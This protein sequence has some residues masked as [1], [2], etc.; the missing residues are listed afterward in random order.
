MH[1]KRGQAAMEFLLTYGWAILVVL[2]VIGAL[3]YMGVLDPAKML[4]RLGY[5]Y[6]KCRCRLA[7]ISS[8]LAWSAPGSPGSARKNER[9]I[10][11]GNCPDLNTE[12][13]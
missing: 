13:R 12:S 4:P 11:P 8:I 6:S 9:Q 2:V 10:T 5:M 7:W 3:A 1:K